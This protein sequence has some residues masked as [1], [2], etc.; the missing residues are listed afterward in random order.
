MLSKRERMNEMVY[1]IMHLGHLETHCTVLN[2]KLLLG[3]YSVFLDV[4]STIKK[5]D[6]M[7]ST[8]R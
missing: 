1:A 6:K 8:F 5:D 4:V 2:K 7:E 3:D